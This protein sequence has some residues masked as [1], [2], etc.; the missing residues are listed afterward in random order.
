[1]EHI[2]Y[3][4]WD[5]TWDP[6]WPARTPIPTTL[7][8]AAPPVYPAPLQLLITGAAGCGKTWLFLQVREFVRHHLGHDAVDFR[9]FTNS[10]ACHGDGGTLHAGGKIAW[11]K[12]ERRDKGMPGATVQQKSEL[13]SMW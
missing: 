5:G 2:T 7:F 8:S 10:A 13:E 3:P 4:Y 12:G 1:M 9:C 6:D 11:K